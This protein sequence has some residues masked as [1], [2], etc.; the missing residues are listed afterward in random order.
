MIGV[1]NLKKKV[2]SLFKKNWKYCL[3]VILVLSIILVIKNINKRHYDIEDYNSNI[4]LKNDGSI[5]VSTRVQY[6][7]HG[8]YDL[9]VIPQAL[10]KDVDT[11]NN[12]E[13]YEIKNNKQVLLKKGTNADISKEAKMNAGKYFVTSD[14][15][16][17]NTKV[18][19]RIY[20]PV[21]NERVTYKLTYNVPNAIINYGNSNISELNWNILSNWGHKFSNID[22][23]FDLPEKNPQ[24]LRAWVRGTTDGKITT[25]KKN[26]KVNFKL[27]RLPENKSLHLRL[28]CSKDLF[29]Y[30]TNNMFKTPIPTESSIAG[31]EYKNSDKVKRDSRLKYTGK[32]ISI[33]ILLIVMT[34]MGIF[35]WRVLSKNLVLS[36]YLKFTKYSF[37]IPDISVKY[38]RSILFPKRKPNRNVYAAYIVDLINKGDLVLNPP[39]TENYQTIYDYELQV[40]D[41]QFIENNGLNTLLF[42]NLTSDNKIKLSEIEETVNLMKISE[43]TETYKQ[44]QGKI[45][46]EVDNLFKLEH[47]RNLKGY[48]TKKWLIFW[49]LFNLAGVI[50]FFIVFKW[51][52]IIIATI[53]IVN[54][55]SLIYI[56]IN[57]YKY[58]PEIFIELRRLKILYR[59]LRNIEK[60]EL[61]DV[62]DEN[63][64]EKLLPYAIAL[65]MGERTNRK[66]YQLYSESNIFMKDSILYI[67]DFAEKIG[68]IFIRLDLNSETLNIKK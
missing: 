62:G 6:N 24:I 9:L 34:I 49:T 66:L 19:V 45:K 46:E 25:S 17:T 30:N 21:E 55:I 54:D 31:Y 11:I 43:V 13:V 58:E 16:E 12:V 40:K 60:L 38:V 53:L 10:P 56:F 29:A 36:N 4:Q 37:D 61:N 18:K 65:N 57:V 50:L 27:N 8:K 44:W 42:S 3:L 52:G 7:I 41:E 48:F 64:W 20:Q 2:I 32:Y 63:F 35:S 5:G 23:T 39:R 51:L 47:K 28:I 67:G 15:A 1:S 68:E 26:G 22:I 33:T 14:L 59:S